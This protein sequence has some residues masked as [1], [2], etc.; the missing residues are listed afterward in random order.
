[1][2]TYSKASEEINDLVQDVMQRYHGGLHDAGV[3][4]ETLMA[5]P[6]L[7]DNGDPKGSA[8]S[9]AGYRC[10]AKIKILGLKDRVCRGYDAEMIIDSD[11]WEESSEET[12]A[13]IIDHELTHLEL[14][15]D[16]E[17]NVKRDDA[18]RPKLR[19]VK[20]DYHFGWFTAVA[21]RHGEASIEVQQA[22]EMIDQRFKQLFLFDLEPVA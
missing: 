1:M 5:H 13:A 20:H 8:V 17:G 19:V 7:D 11:Q 18:E 3:L 14:V 16:S 12:R 2:P 10:V 21:R 9:V 15:T 6:C 4:V 22:R